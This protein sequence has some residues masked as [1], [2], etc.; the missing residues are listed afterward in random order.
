M[1]ITAQHQG[2]GDEEQGE[3][4]DGDDQHRLAVASQQVVPGDVRIGVRAEAGL[5]EQIEDGLVILRQRP[6]MNAGRLGSRVVGRHGEQGNQD[7]LADFFR[8]VADPG[9]RPFGVETRAVQI[10]VAR[11]V[12]GIDDT[13]GTRGELALGDH[14]FDQVRTDEAGIGFTRQNPL[15]DFFM[16]IGFTQLR[17]LALQMDAL[18]QGFTEMHLPAA[19]AGFVGDQQA[20]ALEIAVML[21]VV[22]V[23]E[24]DRGAT[25]TIERPLRAGDQAG[26]DARNIAGSF[27]F[28]VVAGVGDQ[29]FDRAQTHCL[30]D[31]RVTQGHDPEAV[32]GEPGIQE[33]GVGLPGLRCLGIAAV[34]QNTD[35]DQLAVRGGGM[36]SRDKQAE[37]ELN[38]NTEE[39][40][41]VPGHAYRIGFDHCIIAQSLLDP[42][43]NRDPW[44]PSFI[45][46]PR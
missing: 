25:K 6:A 17:H 41:G 35:P 11:V 34:S 36:R 24:G 16:V 42:P 5:A 8:E 20:L 19:Q 21:Q 9:E 13:Q 3:D 28:G 1:A 15:H 46:L 39:Q 30:V 33:I 22:T 7:R 12:T 44:F 29:Q 45:L 43:Y 32:A 10:G 31:L 2:E 37:G 4:A 38:K 23:G 18:G 40:E 26:G 14:R 27:Q